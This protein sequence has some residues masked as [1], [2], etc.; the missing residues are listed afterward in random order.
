[1]LSFSSSF[2]FAYGPCWPNYVPIS[3]LMQVASV[4]NCRG[5]RGAFHSKSALLP[6]FSSL[7]P[8]LT[9]MTCFPMLKQEADHSPTSRAP[10]VLP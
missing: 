1:M 2:L 5:S 7:L 8:V 6:S 9:A 3:C 4:A 10:G